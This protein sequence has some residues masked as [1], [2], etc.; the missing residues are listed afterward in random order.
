MRKPPGNLDAWAAYQRGLWHM[1]IVR[2]RSRDVYGSRRNPSYRNGR[3]ASLAAANRHTAPV[4][5]AERA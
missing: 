5:S 3:K 4:V 2:R 1:S